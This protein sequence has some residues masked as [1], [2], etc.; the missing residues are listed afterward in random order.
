MTISPATV[1][2]TLALGLP[3][4]T[5]NQAWYICVRQG[6]VSHNVVSSVILPDDA[7]ENLEQTN[8][9]SED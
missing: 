9:A 1:Q 6:Q 4:Q 5:V 3:C 7:V 8:K 2:V